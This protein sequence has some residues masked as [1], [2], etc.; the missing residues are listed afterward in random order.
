[1][2][3]ILRM[4]RRSKV[5]RRKNK[6]KVSELPIYE[7]VWIDAEESGDIGWN[8][9]DDTLKKAKKPC[10]V[11]HS[12]G[13]VV[14]RGEDHISLLSTVGDDECSTLEKIPLGFIRSESE[15]R[16]VSGPESPPS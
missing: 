9:I 15:L 3:P 6:L 10:P 11:M 2:G 7:V 16:G 5:A 13:Y 4:N 14:Y 8:D 1:M 12:V